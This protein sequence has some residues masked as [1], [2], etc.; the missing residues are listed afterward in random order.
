MNKK[1]SQ[2][3][4]VT[5]IDGSMRVYQNDKES[6]IAVTVTTDGNSA[7]EVQ[8][9]PIVATLPKYTVAVIP[10]SSLLLAEF[11]PPAKEE[12]RK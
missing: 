1:L 12:G 3:V 7:L 8:A 11:I 2:G 4:R 5:L 9:V 6:H 10:Y